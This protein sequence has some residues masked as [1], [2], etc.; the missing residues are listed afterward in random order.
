MNN[1]YGL[2]HMCRSMGIYYAQMCRITGHILS[3][4]GG[5]MSHIFPFMGGI[6]GQICANMGRFMGPK[7]ESEWHM[8]IQT[9]LSGF[10]VVVLVVS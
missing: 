4:M 10:L 3:F 9:R 2:N 1:G 5:I 8:P 7:F 6:M